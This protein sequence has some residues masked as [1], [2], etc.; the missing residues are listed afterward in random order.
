MT[1]QRHPAECFHPG[2]FLAEELAA[3]SWTVAEFTRRC[4]QKS[5]KTW[6]TTEAA[7][8]EILDRK[9]RV[10]AVT[11]FRFHQALGTSAEYWQ[12]LQAAYDSWQVEEAR[13][14][15]AP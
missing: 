2:E 1:E 13:R 4:N 5:R 8:Q 11:A 15:V 10:D 3:R 9:A 6:L 12:N 7:V 14:S